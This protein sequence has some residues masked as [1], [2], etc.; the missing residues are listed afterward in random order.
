MPAAAWQQSSRRL[1]SLH[2]PDRDMKSC[3]MD[4]DSGLLLVM[5]AYNVF[6]TETWLLQVSDRAFASD[7]SGL[8]KAWQHKGVGG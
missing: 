4:P 8:M 2:V 1:G 5:R 7:A 6:K 3:G